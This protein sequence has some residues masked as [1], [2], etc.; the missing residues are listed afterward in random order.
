[1]LPLT[2]SF[3]FEFKIDSSEYNSPVVKRGPIEDDSESISVISFFLLRDG[4]GSSGK[5]GNNEDMDDDD[6]ELGDKDDRK[7]RPCTKGGCTRVEGKFR[8]MFARLLLNGGDK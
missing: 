1:M 3:R 5:S 6:D 7:D 2:L 8:G 4:I